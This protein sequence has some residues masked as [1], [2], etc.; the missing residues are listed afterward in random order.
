M[1]PEMPVKEETCGRSRQ[2]RLRAGRIAR[3]RCPRCGKAPPEPGLKLC[4]S[5]GEKRRAAERTRREKARAEGKQ[6]GG[7]DPAAAR[8]AARAGDRRRRKAREEAGLCASCGRR[9][10]ADGRSVCE[11]CGDA[12]RAAVRARYAA[13]RAARVC[14]RCKQPAVGGSSRCGRCSALEAERASPVRRSA[15][16]KKR[17]IRRRARHLCVDCSVDT[18]GSARCPRCAYRSNARAPMRHDLAVSPFYT[19]IEIANGADHGTYESESEVAACLVFAGLR[20]DQ[21]EV[22]AN[23]PLLAICAQ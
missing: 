10:P 5:C 20:P 9:R 22:R 18:A 7:R 17:Y 2:Q 19:V 16:R 23:V 21:V 13:R 1:P 4:R 15:A 6:Y 3:G 12:A 8:C 11:P 14:V